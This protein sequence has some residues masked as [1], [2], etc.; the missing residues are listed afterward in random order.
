MKRRI[1]FA[2]VIAVC[3][4]IVAAYAVSS[5]GSTTAAPAAPKSAAVGIKVHGRWV[6]EVRTPSGR[7]V[8]RRAF[9]NSLT[10]FGAETLAGLLNSD[11]TVSNWGIGLGGGFT[12]GGITNPTTSRSGGA[13]IVSGSTIANADLTITDVQTVAGRSG[14]QGFS[15]ITFKTLAQPIP[16]LNGQQVLARVTITFS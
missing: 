4:S 6:V 1:V 15:T 3:V 8:Q 10:A 12:N 5:R 11:W 13:F 16:V 7:L 2:T 9:E 14:G